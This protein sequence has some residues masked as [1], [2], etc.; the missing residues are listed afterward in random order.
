M[1]RLSFYLATFLCLSA[2]QGEEELDDYSAPQWHLT[3]QGHLTAPAKFEDPTLVGQKLEFG[4]KELQV[5]HRH[6][7]SESSGLTFHSA[8]EITHLDWSANPAFTLT[9]FEDLSLGIGAYS[10]CDPNWTWESAFHLKTDTHQIGLNSFSKYQGHLSG[11][12]CC[13]EHFGLHMGMVGGAGLKNKWIYPIL[14][15]DCQPLCHW[16]LLV[17]FPFRVSATYALNSCIALDLTA[18]RLKTRHRVRALETLSNGIFEYQAIGVELGSTLSFGEVL[19]GRIHIGSKE[20]GNLEVR[21][22]N[23]DPYSSWKLES[24]LYGGGSFSLSF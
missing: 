5:N 19:H 14:G 6:P 13:S 3:S 9:S 2:L 11:R 22:A 17:L 15:F 20:G 4:Y 12:L 8:V 16:N 23:G 21:E 10:S 18:K 24:A 1:N 7:T